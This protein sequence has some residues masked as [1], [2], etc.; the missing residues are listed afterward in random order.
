MRRLLPTIL[1][2][3]LLAAACSEEPVAGDPCASCRADESCVEGR[4]VVQASCTDGVRNGTESDVD[5][6]GADCPKCAA[7]KSC[8]GVSDCATA[9]CTDNLCVLPVGCGNDVKDGDE[10]GVDCG[11]SCEG[12]ENG[13]ACA[14]GAD[15]LSGSCDSLVCVAPASCSNEIKDGPE[16]DVDCGG[17]CPDC[18][19]GKSCGVDGDCASSW[20]DAGTCKAASCE[21]EIQNGNEGGVDCGGGCPTPCGQGTS[22]QQ[23][24]D[25]VSG[26]CLEQ[27]CAPPRVEV[28]L[29]DA[30]DALSSYLMDAVEQEWNIFS[31]SLVH[32]G[33][34]WDVGNVS[35]HTALRFHDVLVPA[36][37][38]VTDAR[39]SFH[40]A[41]EVDS[42]NNLWINVYLEKR[43]DSPAF[44]PSNYDSGRPDQRSRTTKFIDHWL[45]RCRSD[46]TDLNE[47]DCPQRRLDCWDR[48]VR[49]VVPKNLK[50]LVQEVV[51]LP[52]WA[53]G[54]AMTLLLVNT[55]TDQDGEKYMSSRSIVGFDPER[56]PEFS[57][58]LVIEWE[59]PTA[60]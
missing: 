23:H 48:D 26:L 50:E 45:V 2:T 42:I 25:C 52:D 51:S 21:D 56:G 1:G 27:L 7:G 46:C 10:T 58:K 37:A 12:C 53:Q 59:L 41:N 60:R 40:P 44:D 20:C 47:Y 36:G 39:L 38:T 18:A 8:A 19:D 24:A 29:D 31:G 13:E 43:G 33:R 54:N 34:H 4:C 14:T 35:Y 49:F 16:T 55:A 57:P 6:G 17:G 3:L 32:L 15:C 22:C 28:L 5:C 11:G 30:D 9:L